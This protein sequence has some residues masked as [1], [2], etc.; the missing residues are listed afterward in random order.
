MKRVLAKTKWSEPKPL[1]KS[2]PRTK[3]TFGSNG[4]PP[5]YDPF[6]DHIHIWKVGYKIP[7]LRFIENPFSENRGKMK[8]QHHQLLARFC[9]IC[10]KPRSSLDQVLMTPDGPITKE[11]ASC[12]IDTAMANKIDRLRMDA[13]PSIE[14]RII[15]HYPIL[16]WTTED[17][18]K[19]YDLHDEYGN[20]W[21][22]LQTFF[23]NRSALQLERHWHSMNKPRVKD[24]P[25][26]RDDPNNIN[27]N[28][29]QLKKK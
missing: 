28:Y 16:P 27:D 1:P 11:V 20:N 3:D 5:F 15:V 8:I 2:Q 25:W 23:G 29:Y 26:L 17:E 10:H 22:F 12:I 21:K 7:N 14:P 13:P 9:S 18:D 19:L 4:K 6:E 24:V